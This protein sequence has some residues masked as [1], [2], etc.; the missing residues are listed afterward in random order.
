MKT[1]Q[2]IAKHLHDVYF[3]GNWTCVCLQE[4]VKDMT[5]QQATRK[6][7]GFHSIAELVY[8]IHYFVAAQL[9]VLQLKGLHA[10]DA[11]S[12]DVGVIDSEAAWQQ[13]LHLVFSTARECLQLIEGI[14]D[15]QLWEDFTDPKYG[16]YYR[17]LQGCI[18]HAH[19][20]LGQIV[21]LKRL[22]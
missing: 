12:F 3:G 22:Q 1:A 11:F 17:N 8:H 16:S 6:Q 19:Y 14:S 10:N 2:N 20:H 9:S 4:V 5:W 21:V 15:D 18:E 7:A 13:L